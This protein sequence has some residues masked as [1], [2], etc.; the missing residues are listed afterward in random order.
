[1]ATVQ[2]S[3][4]LQVPV[5]V[6]YNQWTQFEEF[7][8]FME[9]IVDVTQLDDT[10]L[11]WIAEIGGKRVEWQAEIIE[12]IP[13]QRIVWHSTQGKGN[14]GTVTFEPIDD[15]SSRLTVQMEY[16]TE[17][18]TEALG[19]AVGI[20]D[21]RVQGDLQRFKDMIESRVVETGAWRDTVSQT[22]R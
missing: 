21:R 16:D 3:I 9:G 8:S 17:G 2:E 5:Q 20:D 14:S 18:M 15:G 22:G 10:H 7:P 19:S 13:D 11:R 4:D 6:A 12:Q 1:M